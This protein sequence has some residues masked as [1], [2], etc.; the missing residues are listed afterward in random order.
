[1]GTS[2][3]RLVVGVIG[4][5]ADSHG[6]VLGLRP[7]LFVA[8]MVLFVAACAAGAGSI[9]PLPS[10]VGADSVHVTAKDIRFDRSDLRVPAGRPVAL[11]F[12]NLDGVPHNVAV[13]HDR[14]ASTP[15]FVG[16]IFGGPGR[17][18]YALPA[19]AP[20]SYFFRCDVHPDMSGSLEAR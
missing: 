15:L 8:G 1:M 4:G 12:D 20:G 9:E 14:S 6:R 10:S 3:P 7:P 19:L 11:V 2:L 13:Y 17:R 5:R 18:V 16:E